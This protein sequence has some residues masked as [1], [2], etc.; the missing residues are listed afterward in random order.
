MPCTG[1]GRNIL[2]FI[3]L[4]VSILN[5]NEPIMKFAL[6]SLGSFKNMDFEKF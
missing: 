4:L 1:G 3:E 2:L 6:I 5:T